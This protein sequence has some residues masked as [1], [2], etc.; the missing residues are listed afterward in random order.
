[1]APGLA[2][3]DS[4]LFLS[5][6]PQTVTKTDTFPPAFCLCIFP[7]LGVGLLTRPGGEDRGRRTDLEG[8]RAR[9]RSP[10]R[11]K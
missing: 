7:A 2:F 6:S 9:K 3:W 11:R 5:N 4:H 8:K 10:S 1:V